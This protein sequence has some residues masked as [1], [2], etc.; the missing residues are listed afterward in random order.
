LAD[1]CAYT[2][3]GGIAINSGQLRW[4]S[5]A[6]R[7]RSSDFEVVKQ[8]DSTEDTLWESCA[9]SYSL[10]GLRTAHTL[11]I[12][13]PPGVQAF[14]R[15]RVR[16]NG[17]N[18]G[19]AI[20]SLQK[21]ANHSTYGSLRI[22]MIVDALAR[23]EDAP[24]VTRFATRFL[25]DQGVDVITSHQADARWGLA[26]RRLGYFS[27]PSKHIVAL[28]PKMAESMVPLELVM[29][30]AHLTKGD[31]DGPTNLIGAEH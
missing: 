9:D 20:V 24:L 16:C 7:F 30:R 6:L 22:G 25:S 29:Q 14:K 12:L 11:N 3:I 8:F 2:G 31:G 4:P 18:V 28:G 19:W 13:Y 26:L 15:L 10:I 17:K 5:D 23:P 1:I 21:F 27:A